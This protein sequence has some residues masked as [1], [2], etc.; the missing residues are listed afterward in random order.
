MEQFHLIIQKTTTGLLIEY[1][2]PGIDP[3]NPNVI[4]TLEDE[5][6]YV[7]QVVKDSDVYSIQIT[8][9]Y[10]IYSLIVIDVDIFGR[11]GFYEFKLYGPRDYLL[12]N[13]NAIL[14]EIKEIYNQDTSNKPYESIL[15]AILLTPTNR[16]ADFIPGKRN[17]NKY[18]SFYDETNIESLKEVFRDK[19]VFLINKLYALNKVKAYD[20]NVIH[21]VGLLPFSK[22]I[23]K[24]VT[25]TNPHHVLKELFLNNEK[26]EVINLREEIKILVEPKDVLTYSTLDRNAIQSVSGS[27]FQIERKPLEHKPI[28]SPKPYVEKK[29]FFKDNA[30]FLLALVIMIG[31][32]GF[33][34]PYLKPYILPSPQGPN[35]N[36]NSPSQINNI[37][38]TQ[39]DSTEI[40]FE[41]IEEGM[42]QLYKTQYKCLNNYTFKYS[43]NK[44]SGNKWTYINYNS[45]GKYLDFYREIVKDLKVDKSPVLIDDEPERFIAA[46]EEE[47]GKKLDSL[48]VV[49]NK[50]NPKIS[51]SPSQKSLEDK[52]NK[53][54]EEGKKDETNNALNPL[55]NVSTKNE[56]NN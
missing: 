33:A 43:E 56:G 47:S 17:N 15:S 34:F 13:F 51:S 14:Q 21:S 7:T 1:S 40:T 12:E 10:R 48:L 32:A 37:A 24:E 46:L 4:N 28:Q 26:L 44:R 23:F 53:Q 54:T 27:F 38:N 20:E 6:A 3:K 35:S 8:P 11:S 30:V 50:A 49:E 45:Q 19:G 55:D 29:S 36:P 16:L 22:G 18:Y 42:D 39:I 52:S 31:A 41:K 5:R 25:I 2:S 9:H